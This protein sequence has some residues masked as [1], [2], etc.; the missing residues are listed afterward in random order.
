MKTATDI[1]AGMD[2]SNS[3]GQDTGYRVV[4]AGGN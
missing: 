3:T 1:R 4:G 2:V